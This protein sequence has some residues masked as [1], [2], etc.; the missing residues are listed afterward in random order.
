MVGCGVVWV[1]SNCLAIFGFCPRPVPIRPLLQVCQGRMRFSQCRIEFNCPLCCTADLWRSVLLR[2][3]SAIKEKYVC[4][5]KSGEC[6]CV[7]WIVGD[8]LVK[9]INGIVEL[10]R[11][12]CSRE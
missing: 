1:Q 12:R 4:M 3:Y 8:G 9:L 2:N 5:S 11:V 10:S 6:L 7:V